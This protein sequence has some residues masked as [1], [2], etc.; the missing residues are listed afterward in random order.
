MMGG[1]MGFVLGPYL[2]AEGAAWWPLIGLCAT[3]GGTMRSPLTAIVFA[4][5]L[6]HAT[7]ALLP[8]LVA[9]ATAYAFTVLVMPRSILTEKVA[10]RGHH[11]SREY[12]VD[13]LETLLVRQVASGDV[14]TV[15]AG[16]SLRDLEE[17]WFEAR[18]QRRHQGYPVVDAKGNV[19]GVVT[20]SEL[21]D[22]PP[23]NELARVAVASLLARDPVVA[24]PDETCRAAAERMA[25]EGVGRLPVVARGT[26]G[27]VIGI[28][29]RSDLLK[30]RERAL[31]A[32]TH[33]EGWI[34][35]PDEDDPWAIGPFGT[36][37]EARDHSRP[38]ASSSSSSMPRE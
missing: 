14:Q 10:R 20:R 28:L 17:R 24:H 33:R 12:A 5:E 22:L 23:A 4:L 30:A 8:L 16:L 27:P 7:D 31:A 37:P 15:P 6:T 26:R 21:L 19:V 18:G 25:E 1:A 35:L 2:P 9:S 11:L 29:T 13:P 38:R 3:L 32:E 36:R 34:R